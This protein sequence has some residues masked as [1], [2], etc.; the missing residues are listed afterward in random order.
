MRVLLYDRAATFLLAADEFFRMDPLSA[1]VIAVVAARVAAGAQSDSHD[2]LWA[3][4]LDEDSHVR[5][6][7]M[8][9]PPHGLFVS[10]MP[11]PAAAALAGAL[12]DAGRCPPGVNGA[13]DSTTAFADAWSLQTGQISKIVTAL[14]VYR[15]EK[16]AR[17]RNVRGGAT[18][19]VA[20]GDVELVADWLGAFHDEAQPHAPVD[21]WGTVAEQRIAARQVH[22]WREGGIAVSLAAVSAPAAGVARVG[23]VYTPSLARRNGYGTA[24]TAAAT[25]AAIAAGAEHVALYADQA[26]QTSNSIY[27]AIGYRPDHDAQ[28][29]TFR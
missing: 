19:A 18:L 15:L 22:L 8:H 28:E 13:C 11:Q 3:I 20:P 6:V 21:N 26:N 29:R 24:V 17:P 27:Q 25:A 1:N 16:L 5:G 14:R 12:A 7:A 23:P 4:V 9:T 10:R 2:C